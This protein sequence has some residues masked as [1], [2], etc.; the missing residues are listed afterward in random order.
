MCLVVGW[1]GHLL[2]AVIATWPLAVRMGHVPIGEETA[3]TVTLF[4]TWTLAWTAERLPHGLAGWWDSPI[5]WPIE[6]AFARSEPQLPTGVLFAFFDLLVGPFAAYSLVLLSAL[7]LN[8]IVVAQLAR[9]LGAARGA[10]WCVGAL[11]QMMPFVARELGVLQLVMV[12]PTAATLTFIVRWSRHQRRRDAALIG[13]FAALTALT[14]GYYGVY[15]IVPIALTPLL[16]TGRAAVR[17]AWSVIAGATAIAVSVFA[18]VAAP[19]LIGQAQ[20]TSGEGWQRSTVESLSAS[21]SDWLPGGAQW[22]GSVIAPLG[23]AGMWMGRRRPEI[24]WLAAIAATALLG[25]IGARL[26]ILGWR[27]WWTI[28]DRLPGFDRMRSPFRFAMLVQLALGTGATPALDALW[29]RRRYLAL[30]PS[31]LLSCCSRP[32]GRSSRHR[33]RRRTQRSSWRRPTTV[34]Q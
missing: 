10:A 6:G 1:C 28:A 17:P 22:P 31:Q 33:R 27:S 15:L 7:A 16:Y 14:C 18:V 13:L 24:R 5:F 9:S 34:Q 12:W 20:R 25:S 2:V 26:S 23:V 3:P 4:N 29:R 8:G 30:A 19:V 11:A 21:W 32:V